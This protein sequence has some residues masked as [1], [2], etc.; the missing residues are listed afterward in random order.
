LGLIRAAAQEWMAVHTDSREFWVGHAIGRRV[1]SVLSAILA[2]DPKLFATD[3]P[4]RR[5]ID[6]LLG[7]LIRLGVGEGH[8]LEE[9]LGQTP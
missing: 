5:E 1:C 4:A 3:Q 7:K 2:L 6:A 8:S 9:A